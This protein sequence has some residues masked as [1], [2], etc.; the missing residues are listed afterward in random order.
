MHASTDIHDLQRVENRSRPPRS[1]RFWDWIAER[2]AAQPIADQAS[3]EE[4]LRITREYLTKES[5]L[6]EFGC[7]T[8]STALLH[9]P[10]VDRVLATDISPKMIEIAR[11]KASEGAVSNVQFEVTAIE[12]L[13]AREGGYDAV[14][15]MSILHLLEQPEV[16][17]AK[18]HRLLKPGG[19]F[20]SSTVC[21]GDGMSWFKFIGPIG[22]ALGLLP[23]VR[24]LTAAEIVGM[25]K[26]AGFSVEHE[27]LPGKRKGV[28]VVARKPA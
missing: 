16:A 19:V 4:K 10:Y 25:L 27:W 15:G 12:D 1:V 7:G 9:A 21:L 14:L 26:A 20:V 17:I 23:R 13:S 18:V 28:F 2:Y 3:Y 5:Q 6:L 11:R 24:V 22:Y 8:G